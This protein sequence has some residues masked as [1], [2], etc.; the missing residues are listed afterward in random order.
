MAILVLDGWVLTCAAAPS[1]P[2]EYIRGTTGVRLQPGAALESSVTNGVP[3]LLHRLGLAEISCT[4]IL[5]SQDTLLGL[6]NLYAAPRS[7]T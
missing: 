6:L 3:A 7:S 5:S 4:P 1:L 2:S